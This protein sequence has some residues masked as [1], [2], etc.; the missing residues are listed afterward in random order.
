[1]ARS[2]VW[3]SWFSAN[4]SLRD[5]G[6]FLRIGGEEHADRLPGVVHAARSVDRGRDAKRHFG[7]VGNSVCGTRRHRASARSPGLRTSPSPFKPMLD[8][9][10]VL[11]GERHDSA[12]VAMATSFRNDSSTR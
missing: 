1:M 11:T 9:D 6:G 5:A 12:T 10:A 4:S 3:R 8:D 2:A 7:R